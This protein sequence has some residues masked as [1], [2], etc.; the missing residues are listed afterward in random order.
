MA[1]LSFPT[2]N[3]VAR[4]ISAFNK[5]GGKIE[6]NT[7]VVD[8]IAVEANK[9]IMR[10]TDM[11]ETPYLEQAQELIM[12]LQHTET[13]KIISGD[14]VNSFFAS[15]LDLIKRDIVSEREFGII[16]WAPKLAADLK[17]RDDLTETMAVHRARSMYVGRVGDK[18]NLDF[19]VIETR[20]VRSVGMYVVIG[21]GADDNLYQYWSKDGT[22]VKQGPIKARIKRHIVD[23]FIA[24]AKV[25]LL[26]YVKAVNEQ[27]T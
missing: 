13:M 7:Y 5:N 8:G 10:S 11:D 19:T 27:K 17:K 6:R 1:Y 21:H 26:S 20:Y 3:A 4:A 9:T 2:V 23:R 15:V 14:T 22:D 24:N 16:A 25:N 18:I 12:N